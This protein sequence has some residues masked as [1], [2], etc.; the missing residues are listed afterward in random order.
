M[1]GIAA[2]LWLIKISNFATEQSRGHKY[3]VLPAWI[4]LLCGAW[5]FCPKDHGQWCRHFTLNIRCKPRRMNT[6]SLS[7]KMQIRWRFSQPNFLLNLFQICSD[8]VLVNFKSSCDFLFNK[9]LLCPARSCTTASSGV[10]PA[11]WVVLL[12][13]WLESLGSLFV[14]LFLLLLLRLL[15]LLLLLSQRIEHDPTWRRAL[16][17]GIPALVQQEPESEAR[18]NEAY[19]FG[20]LRI[21]D[22]FWLYCLFPLFKS[23]AW[24][25]VQ[26]A[27]NYTN[28]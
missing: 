12:Q 28:Q 27:K 2:G 14:H 1:C 8:G 10:D 15:L 22:R 9:N 6:T 20:M 25:F 19:I 24:N 21:H 17:S 4:L 26:Y 13:V 7:P 3:F 16:L 5:L 11:V 23:Q 18:A